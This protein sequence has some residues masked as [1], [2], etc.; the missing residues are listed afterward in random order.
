MT[1]CRPDL[2]GLACRGEREHSKQQGNEVRGLRWAG[3]SGSPIQADQGGDVWSFIRHVEVLYLVLESSHPPAVPPGRLPWTL[4][5]SVW[6]LRLLGGH[7][8]QGS[9]WAVGRYLEKYKQ[10]LVLGLEGGWVPASCW[11]LG[12]S[13]IRGEEE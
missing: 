2:H 7:S 1:D 11:I 3:G 12:S 9:R 5:G 4:T 13:N 8:F 10:T 6:S